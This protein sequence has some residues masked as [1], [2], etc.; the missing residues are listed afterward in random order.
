M[1]AIHYVIILTRDG[2]WS[3]AKHLTTG[4]TGDLPYKDIYITEE[5]SLDSYEWVLS[6]ENIKNVKL[7]M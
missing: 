3:K 4:E 6:M 7:W 2:D 1:L 5:I